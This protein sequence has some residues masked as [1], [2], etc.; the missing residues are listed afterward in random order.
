MRF[1]I[2]SVQDCS[3]IE[4]GSQHVDRVLISAPVDVKN[5]VQNRSLYST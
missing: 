3:S 4:A 5:L 1:R 2:R